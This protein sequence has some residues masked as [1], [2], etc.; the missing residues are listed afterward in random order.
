MAL[1]FV[2]RSKKTMETPLTPLQLSIKILQFLK[3]IDNNAEDVDQM[4]LFDFLKEHG[5]A[6]KC[7]LDFLYKIQERGIQLRDDDDLSEQALTEAAAIGDR[8]S[9]TTLSKTSMLTIVSRFH[10]SAFTR[11]ESAANA[12]DKTGVAHGVEGNKKCSAVSGNSSGAE[13][14]KAKV[15]S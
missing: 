7:D 5:E 6:T 12:D 11:S 2:I 3:T 8:S 1:P 4:A 15:W 14:V 10:R 9:S 13:V